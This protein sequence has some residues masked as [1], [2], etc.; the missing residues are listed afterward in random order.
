MSDAPTTDL[1]LEA[2]AASHDIISIGMIADDIRRRKHGTRTTFVRVADVPVDAPVSAAPPPRAGELRIAGTPASG[3]AA[4][5]RVRAVAAVANGMPV[6]GFSLADLEQIAVRDGVALRALLEELRAV[7]LELVAEAPIDRLQDAR[8][9][10]EAVNI[11][12]LALARLTVDQA[13]S[14]DALPLLKA[15]ADLQR[16][17]AVIRAFAPLARRLNP[18]A[19]T[20][21]FDDVKRVALA[22]IVVDNVPSIQV[23][24]SLYGP[25]LAQV[26]LTVGADDVDAVSAEDGTEGPRRSPLEEIRRGIRAAGYDPVQRDGRWDTLRRPGGERAR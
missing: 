16:S 21:G 9:S 11:A 15:V 4:V 14:A 3:S 22:R 17:V 13:P 23:D 7:G 20:T 26:A 2:L 1:D 24:W 6:S 19:P 12:G 25:K 8:G 5:E 18:A 10:I